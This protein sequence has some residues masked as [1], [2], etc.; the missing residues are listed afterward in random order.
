MS[1][2]CEREREREREREQ[3]GGRRD[4]EC[5]RWNEGERGPWVTMLT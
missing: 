1:G 2:K 3:V 5:G 4:L